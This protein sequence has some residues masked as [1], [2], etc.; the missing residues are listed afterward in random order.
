MNERHALL[1]L[2]A[3][4]GT[5]APRRALLRELG[6]ARAV[7]EAGPSTWRAA[8]LDARQC[9]ALSAPYSPPDDVLRWFDG[10]AQRQLVGVADADYPPLLRE[11]AEPPLALFVA[12]NPIYLWHP[13]LAIV[14]SRMPS[15]GGLDSA[16]A[17]AAA[18][19]RSGLAVTSGLAAGIDGAAH[20][21]ALDAGGLTVAVLGTGIDIP[22]PARHA[23][24]HREIERHGVLVSEYPP[25]TPPRRGHFPAR[26]RIIAGLALGTLVIEAALR[27]GALITARLAAESGREVF[28]I[29]GSIHNPMARGCHRL[30]RQGAALVEDAGE[31][32]ESLA[33]LAAQLGQH[34]HERLHADSAAV[35]MPAAT[36]AQEPVHAEA[37]RIWQALGH[38]PV[39]LEH[40]AQRTRLTVATLSSALLMLELDGW[41]TSAH[42]RYAR[43][44]K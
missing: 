15:A 33:P 14:G 29:P 24:L 40:L 39:T 8:G 17:F 27:S 21:A 34:L 31:I 43:K 7:L 18:S 3:I 38:D 1:H 5:T 10:G 32:I 9:Q 26:N 35:A 36:P 28:A 11:I 37:R 20:R 25:G 42:G 19:V 30:I 22:Y 44:S 23:D 41:I 4:G 13:A 16:R 12:G 6:S 2:L